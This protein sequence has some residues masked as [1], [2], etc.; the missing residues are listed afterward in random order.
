MMGIL[1]CRSGSG[2]D[3]NAHA[4]AGGVGLTLIRFDQALL[5][6]SMFRCSP[7]GPR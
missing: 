3:G 6:G 7:W 5:I 2:G 4:R 1:G